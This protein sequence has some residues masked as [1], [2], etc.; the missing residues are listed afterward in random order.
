MNKVIKILHK[1]FVFITHRYYMTD[2]V[3]LNRGD[4]NDANIT[5]LTNI[6]NNVDISDKFYIINYNNKTTALISDVDEKKLDKKG[7]IDNIV[8]FNKYSEHDIRGNIEEET[9][10]LIEFLKSYNAKE[11]IT[12][13]KFPSYIFNELSEKYNIKSISENPIAQKRKIK[14]DKEIKNLRSIQ[15][16]TEDGMKY[17]E[18]I[19]TESNVNENNKLM[20]ND[21]ILTSE[22]LRYEIEEFFKKN[23]AS[24][25]LKYIISTGKDSSD[26]HERGSGPIESNVPILIDIFPQSES[27]YYGDMSRTFIKGKPCEE[28]KNMNAAVNEALIKALNVTKDGIKSDTVHGKV[29]EIIEKYGYETGVDKENGFT[30]S[31]GHSIGLEIHENP[32]I[33]GNSTVLKEN[34]VL[35]IEPALYNKNI[36]GLRIENMVCITKDGINDFNTMDKNIIEIPIN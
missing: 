21:N 18:Q 6:G 4:S 29:C 34:M 32:R 35:T 20:W 36:G 31:T 22:I 1:L 14:K 26:P 3:Y 12:G 10:V 8:S 24:N 7:N 17:I 13:P 23:N 25:K 2:K 30:H 16:L 15:K 9:N 19:L 28:L 33:S 27:G 11:I 5:Y